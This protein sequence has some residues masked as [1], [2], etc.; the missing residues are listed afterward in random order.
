MPEEEIKDMASNIGKVFKLGEK[1]GSLVVENSDRK[2]EWVKEGV[3]YTK[4]LPDEE[5]QKGL[6]CIITVC[7]V[8]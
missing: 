5:K 1:S 4:E 6:S 3:A 2:T 7:L 8:K